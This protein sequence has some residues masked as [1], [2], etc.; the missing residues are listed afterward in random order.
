[1]YKNKQELVM[2]NKSMKLI[3]NNYKEIWNKI[4]ELIFV[5]E[6]DEEFVPKYFIDS[7]SKM[8][9]L[10]GYS[11]DELIKTQ[12]SDI[13]NFDIN[14]VGMERYSKLMYKKRDKVE[15]ILK[16]KDGKH[17]YVKATII[18]F[19]HENKNYILNIATDI[20]KNKKLEKQISG[21]LM[22][23]PDVIKVFNT[24][25]TIAFLNDAG[26]SFYDKTPE[27]IKGKKCYEVLIS[28]EKCINCSFDI[29]MRTKKMFVTEKYIPELNKVMDVCCNPV[30]DEYGE[31]LYVVER[32]RDITEKKMLDKILK[33]SKDRYK[34]IL[35]SSPDAIIII[36]DN[37]IVLANQEACNLID[38][39]YSEII[40]SNIYKY[41]HEKY[42]KILL[43]RFRTIIL[44]K[45]QKDTHDYEFNI[46]D[47]KISNF[48]ISCSYILYEGN[49]AI[50]AV[51]RDITEMKEELNKAA[52]FQRKTLQKNFPCK[53]FIDVASL[54]VP[55][56][57]ISG[58]F[59]RVYKINENL[60]IGI[61]VDVRGKGISA[62]LN[63]SA[64]DI[65]FLEEVAVTHEAIN[66]VN[67]LNKKLV[68]YYEEN[69]IA[70]CCFSMDFNKNEINIVGAGINQFF[71]QKKDEKIQ[72][73]TAEGI[74]LG[75]FED[76][77]FEEQVISFE[78]GDKFIF[79]TDGL[80]FIMDEDKIIQRYIEEVS[81]SEFKNYV[82]EFLM[83]TILESGA[84]KDD[85]TMLAI[86][87]K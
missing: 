57:T 65:L 67:N 2:L 73:K 81:I 34:Q 80:D 1:M 46:F 16:S 78:S 87:I 10:L 21:I 48:Q 84:L 23:I 70:V 47:G 61:I 36:V 32:L 50:L 51:M 44:E 41:F 43:K 66:I 62:A 82:N 40:D 28:K 45:K 60:I 8:R 39:E 18:V 85:C 71:L 53:E 14:E 29:V 6:V 4:D 25:H 11:K 3:Q 77:E 54:Y 24:D 9:S 56:K 68:N 74:F 5:I 19:M 31:I 38:L 22:G 30:L 49:S 79:F 12:P 86:E 75:M 26:Y 20:T 76:S 59:Y 15:I 17:I 83:D 7:N 37:K 42:R 33:D 58:D 63:I 13:L 55:A 52:E 72:E 35:N 27:E 64:F 69:Y